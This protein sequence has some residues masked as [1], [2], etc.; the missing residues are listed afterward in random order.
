MKW[1][2]SLMRFVY[3]VVWVL[4]K[5]LWIVLS[6]TINILRKLHKT[7]IFGMPPPKFT[8]ELCT[9]LP[10][11]AMN[12]WFFY[13]DSKEMWGCFLMSGVRMLQFSKD[14]W[15]FIQI[16]QYYSM[17]LM[18]GSKWYLVPK[19]S[20]RFEQSEFEMNYISRKYRKYYSPY[21]I[22]IDLSW[23]NLSFDI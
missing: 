15:K 9:E 6:Q 20:E 12:D 4:K 16:N 2:I 10:L 5:A 13:I 18:P 23:F 11:L 21:V 8:I 22:W 19:I 1:K 14:W 3:R 7:N 17:A